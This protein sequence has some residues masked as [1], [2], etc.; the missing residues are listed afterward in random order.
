MRKLKPAAGVSVKKRTPTVTSLDDPPGKEDD[1]SA[2]QGGDV[3]GPP[4]GRRLCHSE[5]LGCGLLA[6]AIG[7][8]RVQSA[9]DDEFGACV[10]P[11]TSRRRRIVGR[12]AGSRH[13]SGSSDREGIILDRGPTAPVSDTRVTARAALG[14]A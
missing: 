10:H 2:G 9:C 12:S 4:L 13:G 1:R 8:V 3:P 6:R 5:P 14:S 11:R 7:G